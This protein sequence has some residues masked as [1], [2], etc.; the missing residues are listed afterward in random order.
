MIAFRIEKLTVNVLLLLGSFMLYAQNTVGLIYIDHEKTVGGFNLIYPEHQPHVYLLNECGEI[1][2]IWEGEEDSRPGKTAYLLENG[3]LLRAKISPALG[4]SFGTGGAGGVVEMLTWDN[5]LIWSYTLAD[6]LNRQHHDV[7]YMENENVLMIVWEWKNYDE[8]IENGFDTLHNAADVLW[9]DYLLEV[10]PQT[11]EIAWEWHAWDHLVQDFD[12]T[13]KNYGIVSAH[14]ELIDVNYKELSF[15]RQDF[16]HTNAID[17]DPIKDQILLSVRHFNEIWII[18]H[19]TTSEEASGHTGG[20]SGRGGDLLFR[21]GNPAAYDKG[22]AAEQQL[23]NQHDAQWIDDFANPG[24]EHFGKIALFNN[25]VSANTSMGQIL[26]PVWE[27]ATHSYVMENG[28]FLP[29]DFSVTISHP[30]AAKNYSSNASSIQILGDG[31]VVMCAANQGFLFE[32]AK[33][34][35]VAWEYRIP[36]RFGLPVAQGFALS[37]ND[38]FTFQCEKYLGD[39]PAF[40]GKELNPMDFIELEP[41]IAFCTLSET[42]EIKQGEL[43]IYP[44]PMVDYFFIENN[45]TLPARVEIFNNYGERVYHELINTGKNKIAAVGW[46]SGIYFLAEKEQGIFY[47]IIKINP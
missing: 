15:E 18:D 25:K 43:I 45:M 34:G 4:A 19:S 39:F 26:A 33:D 47:K 7:L 22:D 35:S 5:E 6:S 28:V 3:N 17:Y 24:Y 44:N 2:H 46:P 21:W 31:T 16:M 14:P 13:K 38:N 11:N 1:V 10:N 37:V 30:D 9:P 27:E 29:N 41:N 36:L 32:L 8:L 23:F 40:N 12:P 20:N 42:S